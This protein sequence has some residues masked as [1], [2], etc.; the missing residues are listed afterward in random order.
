MAPIPTPYTLSDIF[1][2]THTLLDTNSSYSITL[3]N[4]DD[5][6]VQKTW[7]S[8]VAIFGIFGLIFLCAIKKTKS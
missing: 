1:E 2:T 8:F 6:L 4:P 3:I 5:D 7:V